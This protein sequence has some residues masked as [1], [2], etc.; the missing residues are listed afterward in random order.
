MVNQTDFEFSC[1]SK[2]LGFELVV[3]HTQTGVRFLQCPDST[4]ELTYGLLVLG[5]T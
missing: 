2:I 4:Q 1:Q 3:L 5:Q